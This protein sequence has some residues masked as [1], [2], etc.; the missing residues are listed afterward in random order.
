MDYN[1]SAKLIKVV[2]GDTVD[3]AVDLGFYCY[4][5]LRFRIKQIDAPEIRGLTQEER[6]HAQSAKAFTQKALEGRDVMV[7]SWKMGAYSRWEGD[8]TYPENGVMLDLATELK[9]AGFQKRDYQVP[10]TG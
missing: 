2:D 4:M 5:R 3:L 1:F 7:R 10:T 8:V 9:K 6:D